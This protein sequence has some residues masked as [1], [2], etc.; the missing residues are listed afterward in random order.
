[1]PKWK[2][3]GQRVQRPGKT[4]PTPFSIPAGILVGGIAGKICSWTC[5]RIFINTVSYNVSNLSI[6]RTGFKTCWTL[7]TRFFACAQN[8]NSLYKKSH[9]IV[10]L[11]ET[12]HLDFKVLK[13]VLIINDSNGEFGVILKRV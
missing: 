7:K 10:M 5:D 6:I 3:F 2:E 9:L 4:K 12:K 8:D 1:M 11:S 13:P